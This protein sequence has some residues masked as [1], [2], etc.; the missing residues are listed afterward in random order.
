MQNIKICIKD[1]TKKY[2]GNIHI[3]LKEDLLCVEL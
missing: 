3:A 1:L 2:N